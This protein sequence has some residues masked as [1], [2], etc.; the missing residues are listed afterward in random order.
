MRPAMQSTLLR[1]AGML[2]L[3]CTS[4]AAYVGPMRSVGL[5]AAAT[6][7]AAALTA[8]VSGDA[9]ALASLKRA[10]Y[11]SPSDEEERRADAP[12]GLL[13]DVPLCRWP[14]EIL[15]HHQRVIVVHEP[16]YIL[17]FEKLLA[18]PPPHEYVHL[19]LHRGEGGEWLDDEPEYALRPGSK[20]AMAGTLIRIV[21]VLREEVQTSTA[22]LKVEG[23]V[24]VVQGVSRVH[25]TKQTQAAPYARAD[26]MLAPDEETIR[27]SARLSRSWLRG[28]DGLKRTDAVVR[29]RLALAAATAEELYW[30]ELEWANA[31]LTASP[32][33]KLCG[34]SPSHKRGSVGLAADAAT[35]AMGRIHLLT[36]EALAMEADAAAEAAVEEAVEAAEISEELAATVAEAA[37]LEAMDEAA[38]F[39]AVE[40]ANRSDAWPHDQAR[41][42]TVLLPAGAA[43]DAW[44]NAS[45]W[46]T[47]WLVSLLDETEDYAVGSEAELGRQVEE[48]SAAPGHAAQQGTQADVAEE[49]EDERTLRDLEVQAWLELDGLVDPDGPRGPNTEDLG[50]EAFVLG[51][52]MTDDDM[53]DELLQ[54]L[55]P[56]PEGGGWPEGFGMLRLAQSREAR[57]QLARAFAA[58]ADQ[59]AQPLPEE[60]ADSGYPLRRRAMR[61]SYAI[62]TMLSE[63]GA[64]LQRVLEVKSTAE[65]LRYAVLRMRV[66]TGRSFRPPSV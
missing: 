60:P 58:D 43:D 25:V 63:E 34:M 4:A 31:S 49:E 23:L 39:E 8:S 52:F 20:A 9:D 2:S 45:A 16:Q 65:R 5:R 11:A 40:A 35:E 41:D 6:S 21:A 48:G 51:A 62:W 29:T 57:A 38:A 46:H 47:E 14:W 59:Q 61:L 26:V 50:A 1:S 10:F 12:I 13:R 19:L 66:L 44:R 15:P 37:A 7:R 3:V 56:P 17:M 30:R 32:T 55:P 28:T 64:P 18:A 36:P 24:M 27:A 42:L 33:P 22:G 54:L 53:P